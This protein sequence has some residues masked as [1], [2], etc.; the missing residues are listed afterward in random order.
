MLAVEVMSPSDTV[1][2]M[3]A[4]VEAYLAAGVEAVWYLDPYDRDH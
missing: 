2:G 3:K 4:K 1:K